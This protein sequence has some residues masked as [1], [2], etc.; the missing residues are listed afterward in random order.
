[1]WKDKGKS[2][3]PRRPI[4]S[5]S[6]AAAQAC[7]SSPPFRRS[8]STLGFAAKR[9]PLMP[10]PRAMPS[11]LREPAH[12]GEAISILRQH[13]PLSPEL[14]AGTYTN[15]LGS[16][17]IAPRAQLNLAGLR[18]VL[19]LRSE[20]GKPQKSLADPLRYYDA[21]YYEKALR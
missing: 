8:R 9:L 14:A 19:E 1:M 6:W 16:R 11:W 10:S 13:L 2:R 17:G 21:Q 3:F 12:K 7:R 20:Y 4:C 18:K 5:C 15:F